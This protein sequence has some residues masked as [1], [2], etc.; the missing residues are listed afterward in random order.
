MGN[1]SSVPQEIEIRPLHWIVLS[2]LQ[3]NHRSKLKSVKL[4]PLNV[5]VYFESESDPYFIEELID[6]GAQ[7]DKIVIRHKGRICHDTTTHGIEQFLY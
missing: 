5:E 7:R 2:N 6:L 1:Y 4:N 3:L